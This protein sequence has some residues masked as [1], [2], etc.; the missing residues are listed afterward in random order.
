MA[1]F[2]GLLGLVTP[3]TDVIS[4][5]EPRY[6]EPANKTQPP[7]KHD[8]FSLIP[9]LQKQLIPAKDVLCE[10]DSYFKIRVF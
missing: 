6:S 8:I 4:T 5:V 2:V 10:N 3:C 9:C 1:H 7:I